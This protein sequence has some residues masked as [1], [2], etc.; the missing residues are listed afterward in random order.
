MKF[1]VIAYREVTERAFV[2]IEADSKSEAENIFYDNY[3][4]CEY[5]DLFQWRDEQLDVTVRVAD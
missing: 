3:S 5:D 2:E 4:N 1:T